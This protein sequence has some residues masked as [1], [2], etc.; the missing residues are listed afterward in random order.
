[1]VQNDPIG[2][3]VEK[4]NASR[5][6]IAQSTHRQKDICE[7]ILHTH[8]SLTEASRLEQQLK[9]RE[10]QDDVLL[11]RRCDAVLNKYYHV[12][13]SI[14]NSKAFYHESIKA[15]EDLQKMVNDHVANRRMEGL[16]MLQNLDLQGDSLTNSRK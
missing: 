8:E 11:K 9:D 13:E 10:V 1:M 14:N 7:K 5:T 6:K 16:E 3:E 15:L 12:R 4:L 2:Q